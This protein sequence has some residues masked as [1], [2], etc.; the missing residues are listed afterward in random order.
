MLQV[1]ALIPLFY[2]LDVKKKNGLLI[3]ILYFIIYILTSNASRL[4]SKVVQK[5]RQNI[6]YLTL[7]FGFGFGLV[8]GLFFTYNLWFLSLIAFVGIYIIEN[9]R[10]PIL[11]GFIAEEV[12]NDIL[13]SV[14]SVQSQLKTIMT[15]ILAFVFGLC[16]DYFGISM[17]FIIISLGLIIL[18]IVL[19]SLVKN[20]T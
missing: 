15:A 5:N 20:K 7:L 4:S 2:Q 17:A 1:I 19:N 6:A 18:T 13:T 12:P 10:K 8:S 14:I 16:A 11:T 3:G 9:I